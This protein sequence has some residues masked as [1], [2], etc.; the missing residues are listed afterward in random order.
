MSG[1]FNAVFNAA[2]L[3][4]AREIRNFLTQGAEL[5]GV[6]GDG[7]TVLGIACQH[8]HLEIAE[9]CLALGANPC[10]RNSRSWTPL[11]LATLHGHRETT[12]MV[13]ALLAG[14]ARA[15]DGTAGGVTALHLACYRGDAPTVQALLPHCDIEELASQTANHHTVAHIAV[16]SGSVD[17]MHLVAHFKADLNQRGNGGSTALHFAVSRGGMRMIK[18]LLERKASLAH[19]DYRGR[20][21]THIAAWHGHLDVLVGLVGALRDAPLEARHDGGGGSM[22]EQSFVSQ[23]LNRGDVEGYTP[24]LCAAEKGYT[25]VTKQLLE[26]YHVSNGAVNKEGR[27]CFH[28]AAASGMLTT[29]L[30]KLLA[31]H[32]VQVDAKDE[33]Q[34]APL[35]IAASRGDITATQA[36]LEIGADRKCR[37]SERQTIHHLAARSNF[38]DW[39]RTFS[40]PGLSAN[41]ISTKIRQMDE[42]KKA[43]YQR[44]KEKKF[45][46]AK[47]RAAGEVIQVKLDSLHA[48]HKAVLRG[49]EEIDERDVRGQRPVHA[50]VFSGESRALH[51]LLERHA[52]PNLNDNESRPPLYYAAEQGNVAAT[53]LLLKYS[54]P[55]EGL[56]AEAVAQ[57]VGNFDC[58]SLIRHCTLQLGATSIQSA[59]R[60]VNYRIRQWTNAGIILQRKYRFLMRRRRTFLER[61]AQHKKRGDA[62]RLVQ[63]LWRKHKAW[64]RVR[65]MFADKAIRRVQ[66]LVRGFVTRHRLRNRSK[67]LRIELERASAVMIQRVMRTKIA[68]HIA[69]KAREARDFELLRREKLASKIAALYRGWRDRVFVKKHRELVNR[70]RAAKEKFE[71]ERA[72]RELKSVLLL[73]RVQ[74][75]HRGRVTA[76]RVRDKKAMESASNMAAFAHMEKTIILIQKATIPPSVLARRASRTPA[77]VVSCIADVS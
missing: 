25:L 46:S 64:L 54:S 36:L 61:M 26:A 59:M 23:E 22:S 44:Q 30:A 58:A 72:G 42:I 3:N 43:N 34:M 65:T 15:G 16:H 51:V 5:D 47:L 77:F 70:R 31:Q 8:G 20:R 66:P 2:R 32:Q 17:C 41:A 53:E 45:F 48:E 74:R 67:Y 13:Q 60:S 33:Y 21:P 76:R 63:S 11:L 28:L 19:E 18:G 52:D 50:A 14:G 1:E 75:G 49:Y 38:T 56:V 39:I 55:F 71:A 4:H 29:E 10:V 57:R 24:L 6:D 35:H 12:P 9:L 40:A 69:H 37:D 27:N 62:A 73:Q 7:N 68:K